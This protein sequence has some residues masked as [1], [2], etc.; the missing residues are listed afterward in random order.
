MKNKQIA[1]VLFATGLAVAGMTVPASATQADRSAAIETTLTEQNAN[2]TETVVSDTSAPAVQATDISSGN[3][4]TSGEG[5]SDQDE[6]PP[7][8]EKN[9]FVYDEA[10][11]TWGLYKDNA[12]QA[13]FTGFTKGTINNISAWYYVEN[14][15]VDLERTDFI[16]TKLDNDTEEHWYYVASGSADLTYT[17]LAQ[18]QN[19]VIDS[20]K[21]LWYIKNGKISY[22]TAVIDYDDTSWIITNG[23]VNTSANNFYKFNNTWYFVKEGEIQ[24]DYTDV[25][26]VGNEWWYIKNGVVPASGT[27][28]AQN[29]NGWWYIK[30]G[31]VDFNYNGFAQNEDGWWYIRD[32]KVDFNCNSVEKNENGWW[33]LRGGKVDFSYNDVAQNRNGWWVINGGKVNFGFNGTYKVGVR[34]YYVSGGKVNGCNYYMPQNSISLPSGGYNLST[35]NIGLKVIKVNQAVCGNSSERYTSATERAVRNF[36]SR[37]KLSVTGYVD[38]TTWKAMGYSEYDWY[39]LGTYRTPMKV[40]YTSN[41]QDRINAMIQTAIDYKNAGTGYKVGCSGTPGSYV[42]CSGL[43]YQCLY[44]AGINPSSNIV[45]HALAIHEY[46]SINLAADNRL[47]RSVDTNSLQRG[48]L[49]FYGR[50]GK[51]SVCHVAIYAGNGMIYDSWPGRGVTYRSVNIGGYHVVRARRVF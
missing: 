12:L 48:D 35:A 23:K 50:N 13:D 19:G 26:K 45:D 9:G 28:V 38:L 37:H 39:N 46:T 44:A 14:G 32:G 40:T 11:K 43:I 20:S 51:S 18:D 31:K 47:G 3:P 22:E 1:A 25:V 24:T 34:D 33:V 27:T 16:K 5:S 49:V 8:E 2:S 15:S 7:A 42:D 29:E 21:S 41:R 36:Q 30:N 4:G 6:N 10:S 17:G